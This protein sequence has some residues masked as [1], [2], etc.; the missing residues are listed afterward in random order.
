MSGLN[1]Y[2]PGKIDR[3]GDNDAIRIGIRRARACRKPRLRALYT[4][5]C[6]G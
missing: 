4:C 2:R 5:D 1:Q 3:V 6:G